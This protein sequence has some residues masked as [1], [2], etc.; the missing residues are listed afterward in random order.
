[1]KLAT[2]AREYGASGISSL[3]AAQNPASYF[4]TAGQLNQTVL[5]A[6]RRPG[7]SGVL[8]GLVGAG[9]QVASAFA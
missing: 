1:M 3:A 7:L 5:N 8:G 4:G 2:G 9:A 6:P